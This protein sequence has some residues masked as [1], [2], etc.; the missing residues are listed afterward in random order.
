MQL[1]PRFSSASKTLDYRS[2]VP[3]QK[4]KTFSDSINRIRRPVALDTIIETTAIDIR[5]LLNVDRVA[6]FRFEPGYLD[7]K[8]SDR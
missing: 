7:G 5:Q 8:D 4:F 3:S 6:I 1:T 2:T